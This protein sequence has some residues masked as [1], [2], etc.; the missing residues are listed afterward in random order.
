[1]FGEEGRAT[2]TALLTTDEAEDFSVICGEAVDLTISMAE[3]RVRDVCQDDRSDGI[4]V[5]LVLSG[6][7]LE[8][9]IVEFAWFESKAVIG[10]LCSM[11]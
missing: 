11:M 3:S 9:L 8:A 6:P 4:P 10:V 1:V 2:K 5:F 7:N